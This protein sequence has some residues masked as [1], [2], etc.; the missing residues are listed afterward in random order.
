MIDAVAHYEIVY[1]KNNVVTE[2]LIEN[3]AGKR[4]VGCFVLNNHTGRQ[5]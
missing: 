2:Y 1:T 4:N 5:G 3:L